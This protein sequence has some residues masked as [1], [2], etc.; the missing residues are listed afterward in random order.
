[1]G[2]RSKA[3]VLD[4]KNQSG[5]ENGSGRRDKGSGLKD[6]A[7]TQEASINAILLCVL[8][9]ELGP[10][11]GRFLEREQ[12]RLRERIWAAESD[13]RPQAEVNAAVRAILRDSGLD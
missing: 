12:S 2:Q 13:A 6:G 11:G 4:L 8:G 3:V 9:H 7:D 10:R 5:W 1:V